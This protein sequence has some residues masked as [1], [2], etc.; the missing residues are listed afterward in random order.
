MSSKW[1]SLVSS[2][3]H[4]LYPL[5][6]SLVSSVGDDCGAGKVSYD[7]WVADPHQHKYP[8]HLYNPHPGRPNGLQAPR[9][10]FPLQAVPGREKNWPNNGGQGV[11]RWEV[12]SMGAGSS[13]PCSLPN[14]S[15]K[16]WEKQM[17]MRRGPGF[18]GFHGVNGPEEGTSNLP[19]PGGNAHPS[20][21]REGTQKAARACLP[22]G[23]AAISKASEP[24][25]TVPWKRNM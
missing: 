22:S 13:R 18:K 17:A 10:P 9:S 14:V 7:L 12:Q 15:F 8:L 4:P 5:G 24:Y 23:E 1:W 21:V 6:W 25:S 19:T 20:Q 16:M 3:D 2:P 11:W